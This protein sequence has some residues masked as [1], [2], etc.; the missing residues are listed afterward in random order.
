MLIDE[1]NNAKL[2][3]PFEVLGLQPNPNGQGLIM[4]AWLPGAKAVKVLKLKDHA[5]VADLNMVSSDGLFECELPDRSEHF[6]YLFSVTYSDCTLDVIDPYQF[7]DEA[8]FGLNTMNEDP[9]NIYK[10]LGAQLIEI[11]VDGVK[12]RGTKFAVYAPSATCV[13]VIGDFNFWDGRR[14]PMA[15]SLLGHW[16]LFVPDLGAGQRYKYELKD[17]QGN[18]LPHKADPVGYYHEQYPSFASIISDHR[19]YTWHDQEWQKSQLNNKLEQ[20]IS[21][22]EVHLASWRHDGNDKVLGYRELATELSEYVKKMGYTHVELMPIM[23]HPFSGSW[24]YQPTGL[25]APTSRFGTIDDFKFFV[26]TLHQNGIGVILDWVP[27]HFPTD[28]FGLARF[29]GTPL[30]E[31]EDPRRGWHPDWNSLIYDFGRETVR[32]FLVASALIWLDY[33]HVDGLRVDAVASMLYWDYSRKAGEWVPNVDG[34]NINY[35]AVSFLK[36]FN[37]QVYQ[38]YPHAMTIAEESTAF[39]GVSRPTFTGGLGFGFK[40]NM[41]WMH[42]SLEYMSIDPYFRKYHHGEMSF[43]MIYAYNENFILSISHDEVTHGK[44]SLLYKMPGDEWQ[45]AANLRAYIGY[46]YAHPGKKLNFMGTE[47][48]QSSEWNNDSQLDWWLL[49]FDKH[50]GVQNLVKDLNALYVS[51]RTLWK[52]DYDSNAFTWLDVNDSDHSVFAMLRTLPGE[53]DEII[54]VS[55]L[56]PVPYVA[57]RLGVPKPGTYRVVLNTDDK[58]YWGSG[59]GTGNEEMVATNISWQNQFHSVVLDLP[60]LATV[61]IK[62]DKPAKTENHDGAVVKTVAS[63]KPKHSEGSK[64]GGKKSKR[65]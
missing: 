26:D 53:D 21:I 61:F 22:Y 1:L 19:S 10:T 47:F 8:F 52:N 32:R 44:H 54:A 7:R 65:K 14:H 56:T 11:E 37:E 17:P 34:G 58:K 51:D 24:G 35:E 40:W 18:R 50:Q 42:D 57:Y 5:F 29:D 33:Y 39:K 3:K 45:Q 63:E 41:G 16:V 23:E 62:R 4:R 43:S 38:K 2:I 55:N 20:P 9:E 28:A 49:K 27:A 46:Q 36:W 31:Y 60:P 15:R 30:Y 13:S 6:H 64:K 12:V 25:F 59:Y 48:A